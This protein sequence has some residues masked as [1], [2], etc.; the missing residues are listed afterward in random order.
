MKQS[1]ADRW[2]RL[3]TAICAATVG[4]VAEDWPQWLGPR[5]DG[6]WRERGIVERFPSNGLPVSW[7]V[8]VGGGYS[9]AAV[10]GGRVF[11][12]DR[13]LA[14]TNAGVK[15]GPLDR[16]KVQGSERIQC[17]RERDG[18][19]LWE[20]QYDCPYDMAYP[21]GPRAMPL[22][23]GSRVYTLGG[24]GHLVCL[25]VSTGRVIWRKHFPTDYHIPT[26]TW[27]VASSPVVDG[28]RLICLVGGEGQ[29][30]V[31]FDKR[32]GRELWR[33]LSAKEPGYSS[34]ILVK[35]GGTRQL[36]AWDTAAVSGLNPKTGAVFWS[37][38]FPTKLGHAIATPRFAGDRVFITSFFDGSLMLTLDSKH[39][40]A[41]TLWRT[42]GRNENNPESLHGLMSTPFIEG[43]FVYGVCGHGELRCLRAASGERVWDTLALTTRDGR[44]ARWAT[45]FLT[46][47][48][49][50]VFVW[51]EL[52][53]LI[54]A[55]LTPAGCTEISRQ[56]LLEPTGMA[57]GRSVVWSAPSFANGH[58]FV[59]NDA[60]LIR[61]DLRQSRR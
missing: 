36:I 58:V 60:E 34:P 15:P 3:G 48:E 25:E 10:A 59:R 29:S 14:T 50:R 27:G 12:T 49:D 53:Q 51:N 40:A 28:D 54:L 13:T 19:R 23:D 35:A 6:V 7:R 39:P 9:S 16:T 8:P 41:S 32:T 22:V 55:R 21:A 24:D 44:R 56:A 11:L 1:W 38:P 46:R 57:G 30:V 47:H 5:R 43:D 33:A 42:K 45:A 61:V 26:Q 18:Q 2:L 37:V 31:A 52:G 17:F 20:H 4:V